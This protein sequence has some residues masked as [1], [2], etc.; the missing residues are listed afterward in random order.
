MTPED[1]L[2]L[3]LRELGRHLHEGSL[4][5]TALAEAAL[6]RLETAGPALNCVASLTRERALV[7]AHRAGDELKA[8]RSR[9]PLHGIPYGAKDL[10]DAAGGIPSGWGLAGHTRHVERDAAVLEHLAAAGAVL[11]AKLSMVELAGGM[12]YDQPAASCTGPGINP[13]HRGSWSGGSS[14]GSGSAV[15]A[16]L[17]PF[18]LG[19]ETWGSIIGPAGY[20]G[21]SG[22][23][24]TLGR[25]SRRGAMALSWT[26]DKIGPL[27]HSAD[28]CGLLLEALSRPDPEDGHLA[29]RPFSYDRAAL[30]ARKARL[31][32]PPQ[33][34]AGCD[35]EVEAAFR[36]ALEVLKPHVEIE[37]APLPTGPFV[38]AATV[39]L[40]AEASAAVGDLVAGQAVQ[41]LMAPETH[42]TPAM[43]RIIPARDY[44]N[45]LRA[46]QRFHAELLPWV[47]RYDAIAT[48]VSKRVALPLDKR[49]SE[50]FGLNRRTQ[51]SGLGN[52]LGWPAITVPNGFGDRGLPTGLQLVGAPWREGRLIALAEAFQQKTDWHLRRPPVA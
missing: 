40:S 38:E 41:A 42:R 47:R 9:G 14:S 25:V 27:A 46:R 43:F 30:P 19:T 44:I 50:Y 45:A 52:L 16:G 1:A 51:I 36:A 15:A 48:P 31:L 32:V 17:L 10:L 5:P 7:E 34:L 13:W 20:C 37:E 22:L 24:P 3:P 33:D 35:P 12:R 18:A 23:R 49:F 21:L 8:G 28:D 26:L 39:I 2:W 4:H 29:E 6:A 11:A